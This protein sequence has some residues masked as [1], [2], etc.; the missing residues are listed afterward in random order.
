MCV[1]VGVGGCV[2]VPRRVDVGMCVLE[3]NLAYPACNAY[4]PCC[5][6]LPLWHYHNFRNYLTNGTIS[7]KK[8]TE[9][10]VCFFLF[11]LQ[12]LSETFLTLRK[13]QRDIVINVKTSS[14]KV[15]VT[16]V[17]FQ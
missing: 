7:G 11:S 4:A 13:I 8:V 10:K 1:R 9:Y 14:C 5:H 15:P 16:L 17:G 3:C 12:L 2:R 6:S